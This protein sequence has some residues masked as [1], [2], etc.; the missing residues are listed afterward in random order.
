MEVEA[1]V[2]SK[3]CVPPEGK[4]DWSVLLHKQEMEIEMLWH[5][6]NMEQLEKESEPC[7]SVESEICSELHCEVLQ[8]HFPKGREGQEQQAKAA[9]TSSIRELLS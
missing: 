6:W 4:R 9:K 3:V 5:C 2:L 1:A 8:Q 7:E